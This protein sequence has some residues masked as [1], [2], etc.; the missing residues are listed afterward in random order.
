VGQGCINGQDP[1]SVSEK[2]R[3]ERTLE[4][5]T[6]FLADDMLEGRDT[7]SR[8]YD[9]AAAYVA[10][11]F[12]AVGLRPAGDANSYFQHVPLR[13]RTLEPDG[14]S[15]ALEMQGQRL[16]CSNGIDIAID[17]SPYALSE[18]LET[19]L[20][21]V[22]WGISAPSLGL[23][24]YAGL[25]V[26]GKAVVLLEGAP[27]SLPGALRAHFSWIQQKERMAAAQGAVAV[28]TLKTPDRE[29][30]SPWDRTRR[31]R[32]LPGLS[33][34]QEAASGVEPIRATITLGPRVA[35]RLF[36]SAGRD[37]DEI[38]AHSAAAT[39]KG[40][41]L[42]ATMQLKRRSLHEEVRSANV[43]GLLPG[44]H[45]VRRHDVIVVLSHLDHVGIGPTVDGDHIYNGAVDNAGGV[46]VMLEAARQ[47][48]ETGTDR[49]VLFVATTGEEKGLIGSEYLAANPVVDP[50]RIAAAISIDG[51][52]A[53]NDFTGVVALGADHSTL[54]AISAEAARSIGASH[55]PDPIPERGNL[56]LSD[57]YPFLRRGV[58]VL[59]PNPARETTQPDRT[60]LAA[61]DDYESFHYHRPSDDMKLPLRWHSAARWLRYIT[62]TIRGAA[63]AEGAIAWNDGDLIG[64]YFGRPDMR[65]SNKDSNK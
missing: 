35:R 45:P 9:I 59:F 20:V 64:R 49:S 60:A 11:Q 51:L 1:R 41:A 12:A 5:H 36:A 53:F 54:G 7:G 47:L 8:G 42:P 65:Q 61:W 63:N 52:M 13:R 25:D 6:R 31:Y 22:G 40:F 4:A 3:A 58:P 29:R 55:V 33:W 37:I 18:T 34:P 62:S 48:A 38:Y 14:V 27:A 2:P 24:D 28:L 17:P 32:P 21:F 23:D 56:A 30:V 16:V 39:P 43:I 26:R 50:R 57:Q 46:A 10:A 15:F 44:T 19:D